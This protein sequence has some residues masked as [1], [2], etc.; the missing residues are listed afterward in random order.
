MTL[1]GIILLAIALS[2]DACAVSFAHGLIMHENRVKNALFLAVFTGMAQALMPLIGYFITQPFYKTIEPV[3]KWIVFSIFLYLGIKII[4][5]A[6][7]KDKEVPLC[8]SISCLFMIAIAT[9][10]DALAAGV[11]LALT[12]SKIFF[13][14][15]IIGCTTFIFSLFGFT[16]GCFL[17]KFPTMYLEIFAG[18]ILIL[19]ALKSIL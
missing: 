12:S 18:L 10:I 1:A 5:E 17:K 15:I 13:S 2:I 8:L 4:Q 7:E 9:S 14:A 16:S 6:F 19:L 11:T 3:G